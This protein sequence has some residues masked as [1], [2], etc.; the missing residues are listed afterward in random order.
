[1]VSQTLIR[2]AHFHAPTPEFSVTAVWRILVLRR[3]AI[4]VTV[5][6]CLV[7][8]V[9]ITLC[10]PTRYAAESRVEINAENSAAVDLPGLPPANEALYAVTLAT[11]KEVLESDTLAL[12]V[13]AQ[14]NLED[15]E[16]Q[17]PFLGTLETSNGNEATGL[18]QPPL[19]RAEALKRFH[20]NLSVDVIGGTRMLRVG[21]RDHN[22]ALASAVVNALV[23]DYL[24]QYFQTRY[25]ATRQASDWLSGQL[26]TLKSDVETSEQRLSFYQRRTGILGESETNNIVMAK[27]EDVNRQVSAAEANRIV[28]EAVWQLAKSGDP[29]LISSVAGSSFIQGVSAASNST[30]LGLLPTLRAQEAQ[31]KA[32]IAQT[33]SR[34][35]P[36]FP[37]LVQMKNQLA[38]LQSS[39]DLE[40][41][42]ISARA[43]N[44]Y[45]A[46][47]NAETME[48]ALLEKQKAEANKLNS[49]AVE[50]GILKREADA[51]RDLYQSMLGK[52]KQAGVLAGIRSSNIVVVD[53]ARP[54]VKPASPNLL[55][56][57]LLGLGAGIVGGI[58][59]AL[60][61]DSTD[62]TIR[63]PQDMQS[64][65][66]VPVLG[67]LPLVRNRDTG[68]DE[69]AERF[70]ALRTSLLLCA[71]QHAQVLVVTSALPEEGKSTVTSNL[72]RAFARQG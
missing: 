4:F 8:A 30:Q 24:E 27:L 37:K 13:I 62:T 32:D 28:K 48:R 57:I 12:L 20:R 65:V 42:K 9:A 54:P 23:N 49:S 15:I 10:M 6:F 5:L 67:V 72:A 41:N 11:Q 22:P 29:E 68:F 66:N 56:N 60:I 2:N 7:A 45:L 64:I 38:E 16:K 44:D 53:P 40:V 59:L 3:K 52:L 25:T 19:R 58:S 63:T 17:R 1:M 26:A 43:E 69:A 46:A 47:K 35:G 51:R 18:E 31:L 34:L 71:P 55:F 21:Y 36:N 14:L 50:Y 39:I 70:R 61:Q 33:A